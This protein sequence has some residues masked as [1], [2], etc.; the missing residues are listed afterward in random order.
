MLRKKYSSS[1]CWLILLG[2]SIF[3]MSC[4]GKLTHSEAAKLISNDGKF[5]KEINFTGS[6]GKAKR[7]LIE[8][9]NITETKSGGNFAQA[10]FTW[11]VKPVEIKSEIKD[12]YEKRKQDIEK[13]RDG[14]AAFQKSDDGWRLV[15]V[16]GRDFDI[17][18]W[19]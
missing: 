9:T 7:E 11:R 15:E 1:I 8:I 2:S 17:F 5:T 12:A 18:F 19:F 4:S 3:T 10:A 6:K 16:S 13:K 14:V